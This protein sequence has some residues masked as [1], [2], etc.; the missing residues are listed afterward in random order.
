MKLST[1]MVASIPQQR[2]NKQI[3]GSQIQLY[4]IH[5]VCVTSA[6]PK[7]TENLHSTLNNG[8]QLTQSHTRVIHPSFV[9]GCILKKYHRKVNH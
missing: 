1:D 2:E 4:V 6:G 8:A 5:Y 9:S 3:H 7:H